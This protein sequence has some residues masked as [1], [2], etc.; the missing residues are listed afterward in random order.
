MEERRAMLFAV[1]SI[2]EEE[3]TR[4]SVN[5]EFSL[6][7]SSRSVRPTLSP[8]ALQVLTEVAMKQLELVAHDLQ[9]FARHAGRRTISPEDV[10]LVA[11]RQ[12]G[13][14][15]KLQVFQRQ[16]GMTTNTAAKKRKRKDSF[17]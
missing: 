1:S 6:S 5:A 15:Q 17:D 2:C 3:A 9:H 12:A 7:S 10:M 13:L 16:H 11:R 14:V 4:D 8:D